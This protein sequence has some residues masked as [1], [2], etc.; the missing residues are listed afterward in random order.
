MW[1]VTRFTSASAER[2]YLRLCE[3][4]PTARQRD[5]TPKPRRRQRHRSGLIL[6][7][8]PAVADHVGG[9]NR[10]EAALVAVFGHTVRSENA[11]RRLYWHPAGK[12]NRA[13]SPD[14]VVCHEHRRSKRR[15]AAVR[16][17]KED[18][19]GSAIRS[20]IPSHREL[21]RSKAVVVSVAETSGRGSRQARSREASASKLLL[22]R[23]KRIRR[24]QNRGVTLPPG[25]ARWMS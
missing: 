13:G 22:K 23:R 3:P 19:S 21:P 6:L 8:E 10:G 9:Q 15:C 1:L 18:P 14:R 24:C 20:L 17:M 7:H 5:E 16:E 25:S 2:A 12:S 4:M 11:G